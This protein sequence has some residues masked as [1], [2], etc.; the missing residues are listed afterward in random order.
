MTKYRKM[1]SFYHLSANSHT[2]WSDVRTVVGCL[3]GALESFETTQ[4]VCY[5]L[6]LL[7]F[8]L[9]KNGELASIR[10]QLVK[11]SSFEKF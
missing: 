9:P 5:N 8:S 11:F 10:F 1:P 3:E 6:E 7:W 4:T 2:C